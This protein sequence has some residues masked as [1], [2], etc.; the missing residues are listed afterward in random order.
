MSKIYDRIEWNFLFFVTAKMGFN[1]RWIQL[2]QK[3]ISSV[4]NS[5]FINGHPQQPFKP[6]PGGL[7]DLG[8]EI[9]YLP[10]CSFFAQ[11]LYHICSLRLSNLEEYQV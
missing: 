5:I 2:V 4:S 10:T 11:K 9:R 8:S 6:S 1:Q 7:G 3:F